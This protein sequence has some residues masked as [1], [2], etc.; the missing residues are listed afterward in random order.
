[1][2]TSAREIQL[3]IAGAFALT[4]FYALCWLLE[5]SSSASDGARIFQHVIGVL[6]L[7]LGIGIFV[8]NA[9]A[10]LIALIILWIDVIGG[11]TGIPLYCYLFP[12]KAMHTI[13]TQAPEMLA[14]VILLGLMIWSRSRKFRRDS[15]A[16][17]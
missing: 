10:V 1:M 17:T 7:A 11:F 8:G 6:L 15:D 3:F 13:W 16:N 2:K 12:S 4:G 14:N 9:R 5:Y